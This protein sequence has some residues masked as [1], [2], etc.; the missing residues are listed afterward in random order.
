MKR[1]AVLLLALLTVAGPVQAMIVSLKVG[2]LLKEAQTL[3]A[4]KDFKA[5]QA[6]LDEAEAV[7]VSADDETVI[8]QMRHAIAV[9]S[10]DPTLPSCTSVRMGS[11]RCDGRAIGAQ[12]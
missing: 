10:S 1:M 12:P 9:S 4:A 6:K 5:A 2:P 3:I 11:T 8:N 7:K